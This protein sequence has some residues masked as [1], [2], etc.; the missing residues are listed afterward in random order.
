MSD[1]VAQGLAEPPLID[2]KK[3]FADVTAEVSA[4]L[5]KK[6]GM[7]WKVFFGISLLLTIQF[8]AEISVPAWPIPIQNTKLVMSTAQPTGWFSPQIP[9]PLYIW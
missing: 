9:I 6:P 1:L 3:S 2:P 8:F 5:E 4:P 7:L